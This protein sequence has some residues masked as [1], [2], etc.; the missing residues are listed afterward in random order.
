[1]IGG[2]CVK[3]DYNFIYLLFMNC[4]IYYKNVTFKSKNNFDRIKT[5]SIYYLLLILVF[6]KNNIV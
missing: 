3:N 4:V 1:M 5:I 2:Q 6:E